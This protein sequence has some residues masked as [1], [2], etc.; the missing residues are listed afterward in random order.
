[1]LDRRLSALLQQEP[2]SSAGIGW[3]LSSENSKSTLDEHD[4]DTALLF[5]TGSGFVP[6]S[7]VIGHFC[8]IWL[9]LF[10]LLFVLAAGWFYGYLYDAVMNNPESLAHVTQWMPE[11]MLSGL[12]WLYC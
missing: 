12:V 9:V 6:F 11:F 10:L 2:K 3:L 5:L 4:A 7:S 1:M 8:G